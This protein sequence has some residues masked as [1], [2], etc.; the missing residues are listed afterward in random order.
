MAKS[1]AKNDNY[2]HRLSANES[3]GSTA[4][5]S[6][7]DM[8]KIS[9]CTVAKNEGPYLLEWIAYHRA[10]GVSDIAIYD[11]ESSDETASM[12]EALVAYPWLQV[13]PWPT[14][15]E[16]SP[17]LSAF[18]HYLDANRAKRGYV[19]LIDLDE[20]IALPPEYLDVP[21][22]FLRNG[23]NDC[24]IGAV[25]ANQRV[26]G[27]SGHLSY[28]PTRVIE[29][30]E[31]AAEDEYLENQWFKSFVRPSCVDN[32]P[33]PHCAR[34]KEGRYVDSYGGDLDQESIVQGRTGGVCQGLRINHY[35][36]KSLEEFRKKQRRGGGAGAN[37]EIRHQRYS[38]DFFFG[39]DAVIN[40]VFRSMD[41]GL[42]EQVSTVMSELSA[43]TVRA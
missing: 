19:A 27:S 7:R 24:S 29:R 30:F 5:T 22:Y 10:L 36:L 23:L 6:L 37:A 13:I 3:I 2:R 15:P 43:K 12:L 42:L 16:R 28:G 21:A 11:N 26:F 8:E 4:V 14:L 25:A 39:R 1:R 18:S 40:S 9:I 17:Q 38:D 33:N 35:I 31:H 34:L 20:F 32:L 41:R